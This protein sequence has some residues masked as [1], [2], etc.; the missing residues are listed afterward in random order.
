MR[1]VVS[2]IK[3]LSANIGGEEILL[4]VKLA[5]VKESI[6]TLSTSSGEDIKQ[7]LTVKNT[8]NGVTSTT[9]SALSELKIENKLVYAYV[10]ELG[11][12]QRYPLGTFLKWI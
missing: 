9:F 2:D 5:N 11:V 1:P 4:Y 10:K 12:V 7:L 6:Y 8:D 3:K